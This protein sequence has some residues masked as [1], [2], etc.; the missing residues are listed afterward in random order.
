MPGWLQVIAHANPVTYAVDAL[1]AL[2]IGGPTA[3]P[4]L[5]AAA[6]TA[7][8]VAVFVPLAIRRYQRG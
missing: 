8:L 6:W 1:R 4:V 7:G 5:L 3:Q 2:L